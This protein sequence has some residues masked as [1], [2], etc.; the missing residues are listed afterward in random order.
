MNTRAWAICRA[1]ASC[2]WMS[3]PPVRPCCPRT[4][5]RAGLL[6]ARHPQRACGARAGVGADGAGAGTGSRPGRRGPGRASSA[7]APLEGP[8]GWLLD[9]ADLLRAADADAGRGGGTWPPRAGAA[10][11]PG[12]TVLAVDRDAALM[13]RLADLAPGAWACELRTQVQDL[14]TGSTPTR[15]WG[16]RPD[17]RRPLPA[18]PADAGTGARGGAV[19][20]C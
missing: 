12:S 19:G 20:A 15:R 11:R 14:E 1:R 8:A 4:A 13:A 6:R 9:N 2:P 10:R 5:G 16:L 3:S 17:R 18:S 7:P